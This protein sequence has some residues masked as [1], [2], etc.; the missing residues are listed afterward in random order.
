MPVTGLIMGGISAAG[1]IGGAAIQSNA[2]GNAASAQQQAAAQI[3]QQAIDA[4]TKAASTVAAATTTANTG[5]QGGATQGNALLQQTLQQQIAALQPYLKVGAL[6]LGELQDIFSS[7]GALAA[8]QNQFAFTEKDYANSP[9]F[10]FIQQQA[11]QALGRSAAASGGALSGGLVRASDRLNTGL[12]ST[13][14]DQAFNRALSTYNTNRQ[15]L[16]TR[17]Q[18]LTNLTGL[19]FNATGAENQDIGVSGQLRNTNIQNAAGQIAANTINSGVYGGSTG[20]WAA[21][22]G[23][24]ALSGAA[25]AQSQ[26]DLASGKAWGN[27]VTGIANTAS[28][29]YSQTQLPAGWGSYSNAA[30]TPGIG[31]LETTPAG[32]GSVAAPAAATAP[33]V[34]GSAPTVGAWI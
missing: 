27:A 25:N 21:G 13:Y 6:S 34:A 15:N 26:A 19:G 2:A 3:R 5:I 1:A 11:N 23:A 20:L 24:Q 22:I 17:I 33:A 29:L 31:V 30:N 32:L 4:A 16:L 10:Q 18:G 9:E 8:P 14:L 7:K 28:Q 12:T